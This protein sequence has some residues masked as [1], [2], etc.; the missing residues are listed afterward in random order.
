MIQL[1]DSMQRSVDTQIEN[2]NKDLR[3][4]VIQHTVIGKKDFSRSAGKL[5]R[6]ECV[7]ALG[8]ENDFIWM[9]RN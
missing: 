4:P 3:N 9:T 5:M 7:L 2:L 6:R 1:R 8:A